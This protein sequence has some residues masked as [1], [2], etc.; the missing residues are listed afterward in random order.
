M[1]LTGML[2][3]GKFG[4]F[5]FVLQSIQI[6]K[7]YTN[8]KFTFFSTGMKTDTA[9]PVQAWTELEGPRRLR[10]P[11]FKTNRHMKV[12]R[13]SALRSGY[14]YAPGNISGTY[15]CQ[16][17]SLPQDHSAAGR[18]VPMKNSNDTIG[19]QTCDLPACSSVS[20]PTA[21]PRAP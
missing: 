15:F 20:Q 2:A 1:N 8:R 18:I 9:K 3:S 14:L 6:Q 10:L 19:N 21:P 11:V 4:D 5:F 7:E 13:F 16:M 12:V 17:L